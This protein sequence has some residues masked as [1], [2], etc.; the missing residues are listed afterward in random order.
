MENQW[1]FNSQEEGMWGY[2][3]FS[4][5]K[6]AIKAGIEYAKD[7]KWGNLYVGQIKQEPVPCCIDI[8]GII[9]SVG[10]SID[11]IDSGDSGY[12][13]N[14]F[15]S[16]TNEQEID[17]ELMLEETFNKWVEKH[18]IKSQAFTIKNVTKINLL[19]EK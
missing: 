8:D 12:S 11:E 6:E 17:L 19:E 1:T 3:E 13:E 14:F 18:N 16:L 4:T 10:E 7:E 9:E 2:D 15:N 5:K